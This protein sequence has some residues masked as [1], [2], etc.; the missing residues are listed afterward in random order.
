[1]QD[2][3]A[4]PVDGS[5]AMNR[6]SPAS[7][8]VRSGRR[9]AP[10]RLVA[11]GLIAAALLSGCGSPPAATTGPAPRLRIVATFSVPADWAREIG[12]PA[13]A[14]SSLVGPGGDVHTFDPRPADSRALAQADLV[15]AL[16]SGLEPWLPSLLAAAGGKAMHLELAAATGGAVPVGATPLDPHPWLDPRLAGAMVARLAS[17]LVALDPSGEA[18]YRARAESYE[19]ELAALDGWIAERVSPLPADHRRLVTQHD[20]LC[21]Y[22]RRYG[23]EVIGSVLASTSTETADPSAASLAAL[24]TRA[25]EA[26]AIAFF[27]EQGLD[28]RL[29]ERVAAEAG[30]RVGA[31][32]LASGLAPPGQPG[33]TYLQMMRYDTDA[34]V[35]ALGP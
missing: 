30:A 25:R 7:L 12:G 28:P 27:P 15:V 14:V 18:G 17:Q 31:P 2:K 6:S 26:G 22:A 24:A 21:F 16:G 33:A 20:F 5:P 9:M 35:A 3:I 1:M 13:V 8:A 11:G 34:L 32:L 29:L 4:P 10:A 19:A 23:L